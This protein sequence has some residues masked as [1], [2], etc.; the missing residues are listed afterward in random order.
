M[1]FFEIFLYCIKFNVR[2]ERRR[3]HQ[4]GYITSK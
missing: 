2:Y 1:V 3:S 4:R